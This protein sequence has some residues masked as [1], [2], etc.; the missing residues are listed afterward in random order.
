MWKHIVRIGLDKV[1]S[2]SVFIRVRMLEMITINSSEY[3]SMFNQKKL[4]NQ[5]Q[6]LLLVVAR[7]FFCLSI[8]HLVGTQTFP[9]NW[10]FLSPYTHTYISVS[11][12]KKYEFFG[13]FY[14]RTKWMTP[15]WTCIS[16]GKKYLFF[17]KF[18]MLCFLVISVL[19]FTFL[20]YYRQNGFL[21]VAFHHL[22]IIV[23]EKRINCSKYSES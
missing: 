3:T 15:W 23:C 2:S 18:G 7:A 14:V 22:H 10:H 1:L 11:V 19:R 4:L 6:Q 12:S 8:F 20:L 9:Q 17:G 16:W 5:H 21:I 13:K